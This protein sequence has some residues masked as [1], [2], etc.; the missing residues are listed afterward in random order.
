MNLA[1]ISYAGSGID[2]RP[3]IEYNM[4]NLK[5]KID[6]PAGCSHTFY[7]PINSTYSFSDNKT[8]NLSGNWKF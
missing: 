6:F 7:K 1:K 8:V 2:V 4:G 3:S 5:L